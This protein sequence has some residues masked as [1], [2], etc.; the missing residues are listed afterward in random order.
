MTIPGVGLLIATTLV[1]FVGDIRRFPSCRH[2]ASDLGLT[3]ARIHPVCDGDS[4]QSPSGATSTCALCSSTAHARFCS[5]LPVEHPTVCALG[6]SSAS[7]LAGTTKPLWP[8]SS[9]ASSGRCGS[10]T[11]PS[12]PRPPGRFERDNTQSPPRTATDRVDGSTGRTGARRGREQGWPQ[13]PCHAIGTV[14]A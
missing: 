13:G 11:G 5:P 9:P 6:L 8:T 3:P 2:F 4:A 7:R 12:T 14:R 1:V 10:T